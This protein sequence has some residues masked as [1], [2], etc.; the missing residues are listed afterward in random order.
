MRWGA[1]GGRNERFRTLETQVADV[2][3][4]VQRGCWR[5]KISWP[6]S[7]RRLSKVHEDEIRSLLK[8]HGRLATDV[9]QLTEDSDLYQAGLTSLTTVNLMLAIEERFDVEFLDSML[10]RKTFGTI[11]SLAD[12]VTQLRGRA[13]QAA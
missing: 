9:A 5:S 2:S 1:A 12:A 3:G 4:A 8:E 11:R 6:E 7:T 13:D 10:G